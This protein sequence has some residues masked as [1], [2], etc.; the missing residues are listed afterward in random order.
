[1][2]KPAVKATK[3]FF[4]ELRT[5]LEYLSLGRFNKRP[6]LRKIYLQHK[7]TLSI[8]LQRFI[9]IAL[10][11]G[12]RSKNRSVYC[13][14]QEY[15]EVRR[16]WLICFSDK[17]CVACNASIANSLGMMFQVTQQEFCSARCSANNDRTRSRAR[18]TNLSVRGVDNP[19]KDKTVR[20]KADATM[21]SKYGAK[22]A[23]H[24]EILVSKRI[25]T[26]MRNH[27]VPY[28]FNS[29]AVRDKARDTILTRYGVHNAMQHSD[30][31]Y[32]CLARARNN[33]TGTLQG[34]RFTV[35]G[36]SEVAMLKALVRKYGPTDIDSQFSDTYPKDIFELVKVLPDFYVHSLDTYVECKSTWTLMGRS[37]TH[38]RGL[39]EGNLT[40]N[41]TK[42]QVCFEAGFKVR[43]IIHTKKTF[44]ST[45]ITLVF[46]EIL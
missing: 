13:K 22:N 42:A 46:D 24:S 9:E 8:R 32:K 15:Q 14:T 33:H 11:E 23:S 6:I 3:I 16:K 27:G 17:K 39:M 5:S 28:S 26:C 35:Q 21:L 2:S 31:A 29:E 10:L 7:L 4:D 36:W 43:W 19:S 12:H 20:A 25:E 30:I 38:K 18:S 41:K 40:K 37:G 45:T 44:S 34:K 1:M